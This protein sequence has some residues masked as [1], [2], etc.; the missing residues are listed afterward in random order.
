MSDESRLQESANKNKQEEVDVLERFS[1]QIGELAQHQLS[2]DEKI[3]ETSEWYYG[4]LTAV[5]NRNPAIQRRTPP[6]YLE[7]ACYRHILG[8]KLAQDRRFESTQFDISDRDL[9][10]GREMAVGLGLS[11]TVERVAGD[12]H[13]LPFA[14]NYFDLV[15]ISAS[16]HHTRSPHRI[17]EEAMRVLADGGLFYCQ[18]EPCERL[19]SFYQFNANR[20][21]Q[22]TQFEAHLQKRDLMRLISSPY[23]GARNA[24]MF[25]RVENDRI[26]LEMYYDVFNRHGKVLE[27]VLY[28]D[29]LLTEMDKKILDRADLPEAG[30]SAYIAELVTS[31]MELAA[32]LLSV[33]DR[34]LGYSLPS[35]MEIRSMAERVA[36]A[37]KGRP[38]NTRSVE[39]QKA[40]VKIFGGSLR[41]VVER[42]RPDKQRAAEKFRRSCQSVNGVK[43]DD[44][45]YNN[46]GLFFW[47]KLLPD[48]QTA[49]QE[50]IEAIF[51]AK[52]WLN[53]AH[54]NQIRMMV[55]KT[56]SPILRIQL[57]KPA[58]A[59]MR[60]RV[61]VDDRLPAARLRVYYGD[62]EI[63]NEVFAQSED[64]M[65]RFIYDQALTEVHF[66]L[67]DLV[68]INTVFQWYKPEHLIHTVMQIRKTTKAPI[69]V[70]GNYLF[71]DDD[72]PD[73]VVK[74]GVTNM[75][76]YYIERLS[77]S[78]FAYENVLESLSKKFGFTY[79]SKK[80]LFCANDS[81][82]SCPIMF[83]G[84]LFTYDRHHLSL[85]AANY[86]GYELKRLHENIFR[87]LEQR[88]LVVE[89]TE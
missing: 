89:Q 75:D 85:A 7:I 87:Q 61:V 27:Q 42:Q 69:V 14:D 65:L 5:L 24:E 77:D 63:V 62:K 55:S 46:S 78:T 66:E 11:D 3:I 28:C 56:S 68:I 40:M 44:A 13:D 16:I 83:N 34:L 43:L 26:P 58:L 64:R 80:R 9:E 45:V 21:A 54:D 37:L 50:I 4:F 8:Y 31:E 76:G 71:F 32:P 70:F 72:L 25:G 15:M 47:D 1:A 41:F 81:V 12:F 22:H 39:W 17:I 60:Y 51:P 73:L 33:Q 18:R 57:P 79:I 38:S 6:R 84:K 53:S 67:T 10:I 20:P 86:L 82:M 49:E 36:A 52:Y 19:F 88:T 35:E 59:V 48:L 2:H 29:G 30:L 74:H 23:P